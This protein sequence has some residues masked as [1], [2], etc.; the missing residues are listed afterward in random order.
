VIKWLIKFIRGI[1]CCH[2]WMII[3]FTEEK[4]TLVCSKCGGKTVA[5]ITD[6]MPL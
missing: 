5:K 1:F 3:N 6:R 4:I 2:E